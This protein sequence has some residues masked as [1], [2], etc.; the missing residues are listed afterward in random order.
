M[1]TLTTEIPPIP[2]TFLQQVAKDILNKYG[3]D[4]SDIAVVFP[5]KRA[6][7]FLNQ[8]LVRQAGR[9]LWSPAYITIS[10]LFRQH[11]PLTVADPILLVC[12]L[13]RSFQKYAN[14]SHGET[15]DQF[16]GWGQLLLADFDDIDKN[17]ADAHRVFS[18]VSN[19]EQ[20]GD[21]SYLTDDQR[22][23]LARFFSDFDGETT[24]LR[25][26]FISLWDVLSDIYDDFRK[27]LQV[28]GLAYEGM[29]YRNVVEQEDLTFRYKK[30]LFVG[31]NVVQQV[32]QTLFH[33]LKEQGRAAF[34]WDYDHYYLGDN[35][36]EQKDYRQSGNDER[37]AW[38]EAG[39]YIRQYLN[40]FPNELA[41]VS[42]LYDQL[43]KP[44]EIS[45]ISAATETLQAHYVDDW[46]RSHNRITDGNRTAIVLCNEGL[47]PTVI[48]CIPRE[49]G[50]VNITTGFPLQ[51]T[52]ISTEVIT[53][54][55]EKKMPTDNLQ[56]VM[57]L[58]EFVK[59][60]RMESFS[61][62]ENSETGNENT[63]PKDNDHPIKSEDGF[64]EEALFRMYTLLN[65]M[66]SL[67]QDGELTVDMTTLQRLLRQL[68]ASTSIPFH[69]EPAIGIQVMG[70][71]ETRNIDF[72]HVLM[73][74]C[75]EGNMPRGVNDASFIP[76]IVR[77]AYGLTTID[78]KVAI[79][80]YYFHRLIQRAK[81]VTILY[82]NSTEGVQTGE[83]SRF[84]LQ[85]SVELQQPIRQLTLTCGSES[86]SHTGLLPTVEKTGAVADRLATL[87]YFSPT[88]FSTYLRCP[89]RFFY[90][91]ISETREPDDTE[92]GVIDNRTFGN[93]FHRAAQLMYEQLL[94]RDM[95]TTHDIDQLLYPQNS[96][97]LVTVISQAVAEELFHLPEGTR[98]HPRLNGMQLISTQVV[99]TYLRQLL[100]IDRQL[101]P[102]C[103]VAHEHDVRQ[104]MT[105]ELS[106]GEIRKL[107]IGGRI[108]RIDLVGNTLRVVDYKTGSSQQRPVATVD[109]I[110]NPGNVRLRH[111]D[112][113]LQAMLYSRILQQ[114]YPQASGKHVSPA[115]LF[116]QH[117]GAKD[118]NPV[119][120]IGGNSIDDISILGE[121]FDC[122]LQQLA[123]E[124]L[125]TE[126]PFCPTSDK[127]RCTTCAYRMLCG[128][129]N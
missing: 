110:F 17:M 36:K 22:R 5:N 126:T 61:N 122:H 95:I 68:I 99:E 74:S 30:Y 37:A 117:A 105:V 66:E 119:L 35:R 19:L 90:R 100:R 120:S 60:K 125:D 31:F 1:T 106:S 94:P 108:D 67:L 2:M 91:Y 86:S 39:I 58:K 24:Q 12:C 118:Y 114:T 112:Y 18:H 73:L 49:A 27:S 25:S 121:D 69:G 33:R 72:E 84:M 45:F 44:K 82:G 62:N 63:L 107:T 41:D 116:V 88:A 83:M 103:V 77:Q 47:L 79:Y 71:L 6:S 34:Y 3:T 97:K 70:V 56:M 9:P 14:D 59:E 50:K 65:R 64:R 75:N 113:Y 51:L 16:Y 29:L 23:A 89:I 101:A 42:E 11:S 21:L 43:S 92:E 13:Y 55:T 104:M 81:D 15:L 124:I 20:I 53:K 96:S 111:T 8:E 123:A 10:D 102:F 93:V 85:L 28:R 38:S 57:A 40:R 127:A 7:L 80:S 128:F 87:N 26:R 109:D 129:R 4:L 48:H 78:N 98:R 46:L 115:L 54:M 76:H 52:R 32:E